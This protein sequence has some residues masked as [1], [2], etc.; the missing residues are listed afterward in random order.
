MDGWIGRRGLQTPFISNIR[1]G[2]SKKPARQKSAQ[3]L[4]SRAHTMISASHL[5]YQD[6]L[7]LP[8]MR[9]SGLDYDGLQ[10]RLGW[11]PG[12]TSMQNNLLNIASR[13]P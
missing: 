13:T 6:G 7:R 11:D 3:G 4:E 2:E 9:L 10:F 1:G 8:A 5:K 12:R